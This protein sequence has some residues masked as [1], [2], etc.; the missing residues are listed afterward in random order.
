MKATSIIPCM[1]YNDASAA[2]EWL[3]NAFGFKKHLIVP[4][5]NNTIAHSQ[6]TLGDNIMIMV[7]SIQNGSEISNYINLPADNNGRV[8]QSPYIVVDDPDALYEQAVKHGAKILIEIK[9]EDYG[10]RGFS[11]MDPEGNLW[12][13]GSYNPWEEATPNG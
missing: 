11:C 5:E 4:G 13:F 7:G 6:L 2:I 12:N 9:T 3:C 1:S 8:T 10:G